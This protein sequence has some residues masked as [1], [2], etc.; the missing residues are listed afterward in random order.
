MKTTQTTGASSSI[1]GDAK[2]V[3]EILWE[4]GIKI[5]KDRETKFTFL[6][7]ILKLVKN[8]VNKCVKVYVK[9][10]SKTRIRAS[11][12]SK[13]SRGDTPGPP[14]KGGRSRRE[15]ERRGR[16]LRHGC[17]GDGRPC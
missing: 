16:G 8:M 7:E 4:G 13:F 15:R 11:I 14:L 6:L 2:C 17:R 1:P 5:K 12:I 9:V 3:T 10:G